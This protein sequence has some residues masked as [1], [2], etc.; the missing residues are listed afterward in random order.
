MSGWSH[1]LLCRS[2]WNHIEVSVSAAVIAKRLISIECRTAVGGN[3]VSAC[4]RQ[5]MLVLIQR[6]TLNSFVEVRV[7]FNLFTSLFL[8]LGR[9]WHSPHKIFRLNLYLSSW[10]KLLFFFSSC[11]LLS[12]WLCFFNF[13]TPFGLKDINMK[14]I[15]QQQH[16]LYLESTS[17]ARLPKP[18]S[19]FQTLNVECGMC[20]KVHWNHET[21]NQSLNCG[22]LGKRRRLWVNVGK[23]SIH[24]SYG[25]YCIFLLVSQCVAEGKW[26]PYL[27]RCVYRGEACMD[28]KGSVQAFHGLPNQ[29]SISLVQS[30]ITYHYVPM[31]AG[32]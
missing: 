9:P 28:A 14:P 32:P 8:F 2:G 17:T 15:N 12:L 22:T 1:F 21:P 18:I 20:L 31:G 30:L 19:K 29:V 23:Y 26:C 13:C 7:D 3:V 27:R 10:Q 16:D 24:G 5:T 11:C 25:N 4:I 6:K